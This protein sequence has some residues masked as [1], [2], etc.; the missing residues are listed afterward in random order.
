MDNFQRQVKDNTHRGLFR[1]GL[2]LGEQFC[3]V[4]CRIT[5][6]DDDDD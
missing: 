3:E 1:S 2:M 5:S 6:D 4:Y